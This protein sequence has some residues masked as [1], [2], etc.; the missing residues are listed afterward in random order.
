MTRWRDGATS[1][2]RRE[3]V[4]TAERTNVRLF[5]CLFVYHA[6][7]ILLSRLFRL[8]RWLP[9]APSTPCLV[10]PTGWPKIRRLTALRPALAGQNLFP[11][12]TGTHF[13]LRGLYLPALILLNWLLLTTPGLYTSCSLTSTLKGPPAPI[14]PTVLTPDLLPTSSALLG[15]RHLPA[16][17][18]PVPLPLCTLEPSILLVQTPSRRLS[19]QRNGIPFSNQREPSRPARP[20][21][22]AACKEAAD[23]S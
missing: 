5:V 8:H 17:R 3:S 22:R 12:A 16:I 1:F 11:K 4:H 23:P 14:L 19:N 20:A 21:P 6:A 10:P 18:I 9:P 13:L 7:A 15:S 2:G